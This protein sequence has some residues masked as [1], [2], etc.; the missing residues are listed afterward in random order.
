[1]M[2]PVESSA[3]ESNDELDDQ[4]AESVESIEP[5]VVVERIDANEE[6]AESFEAE[7]PLV[8]FDNASGAHVPNPNVKQLFGSV[9]KLTLQFREK[10]ED[11]EAIQQKMKRLKQEL[12]EG[13]QKLDRETSVESLRK[14]EREL[15]KLNQEL[16]ELHV[17]KRQMEVEKR[18]GQARAAQRDAR[19]MQEFARRQQH[20]KVAIENLH[21]AGMHEHARRLEMELEMKMESSESRPKQSTKRAKSFRMIAPPVS[22]APVVP[23][24]PVAPG[25]DVEL[26]LLKDELKSVREEMRD[27]ARRFD[28]VFERLQH[29][30]DDEELDIEEAE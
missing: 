29:A 17:K 8:I 11:H 22:V 7:V 9:G 24:T 6:H 2:T 10:R 16:R 12:A 21:A 5:I 14:A 13:L 20:I 3:L 23:A 28:E 18:Q 19:R 25:R 27:M 26:D 4:Q 15:L 1:M 30:D